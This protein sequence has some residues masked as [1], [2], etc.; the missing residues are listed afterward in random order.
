MMAEYLVHVNTE[1]QVKEDY[2]VEKPVRKK[3]YAK[4]LNNASIMPNAA[5]S[6]ITRPPVTMRR[7]G[8]QTRLKSSQD[9]EMTKR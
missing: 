5:L 4:I 1:T 2:G 3:T 9:L 7:L 8:Q 6:V